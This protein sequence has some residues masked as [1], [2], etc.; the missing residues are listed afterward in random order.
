[1]NKISYFFHTYYNSISQNNINIIMMPTNEEFE[2]ELCKTGYNIYRINMGQDWNKDIIRPE[3]HYILPI[4]EIK[5]SINYDVFLIPRQDYKEN[6]IA[7][8]SNG[9][10]ST[11]IKIDTINKYIN[12]DMP[13][14]WAKNINYHSPEFIPYWKNLIHE[15]TMRI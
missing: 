13:Y 5:T 12:N 15:Y 8:I 2:V 4:G 1:M 9:I 3:N 14:G 10:E 7:Q 11:I 6:L